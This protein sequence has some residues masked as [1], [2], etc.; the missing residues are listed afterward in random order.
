MR[1]LYDTE[2]VHREIKRVLEKNGSDQRRVIVVAYIGDKAEAFLPHPSGLEIVC[3][4]QPISTSAVALDSLCRRGAKLFYVQRLHMK[5]YWSSNNGCVITSANVSASGLSA[6][7]LKEIGVLL[8][9][10]EL[11]IERLL[12]SIKPKKVDANDILELG[13]R[14]DILA[15]KLK[16]LAAAPKSTTTATFLEWM[17]SSV[18]KPWKFGFWDEGIPVS[19]A[20]KAKSK[21]EYGV[22]VPHDWLNF[23]G[24]VYKKGDWILCCN[25]KKGTRS[26]PYW[27][28]VDYV[29]DVEKSGLKASFGYPRQAFQIHKNKYYPYPPFVLDV[30]FKRVFSRLVAEYRERIWGLDGKRCPSAFL[31]FMKR[32]LE[33]NR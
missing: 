12:A 11:D 14:T 33:K 25:L 4:L 3:C 13:R 23:A 6:G 31:K 21:K 5:V 28:Y 19:K 20:A 10:D 7:G 30:A 16:A 27:M 8:N 26:A 17:D 15:P 9:S 32:N 1:V 18:R 24:N 2:D 22:N 29:V